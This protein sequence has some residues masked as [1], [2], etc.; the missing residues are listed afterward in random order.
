M[1]PNELDEF[2]MQIKHM[3][4]I[5]SYF[6][7]VGCANDVAVSGATI[8]GQLLGLNSVIQASLFDHIL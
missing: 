2:D 5:F 8:T 4:C 3:E 6:S 1:I 7:Y